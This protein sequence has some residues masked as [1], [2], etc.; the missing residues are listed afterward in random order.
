MSEDKEIVVLEQKTAEE[1]FTAEGKQWIVEK[2]KKHLSIFDYNIATKEGRTAIN[3]MARKIGGLQNR[4]TDLKKQTTAEWK[5]KAKKIDMQGKAIDDALES[6]KQQFREPLT[7]L[8]SL[9]KQRT[10]RINEGRNLL[11]KIYRTEADHEAAKKE[12]EII[13]NFDFADRQEEAD[14]LSK[15]VET[16]L[17]TVFQMLQQEKIKEEEKRAE[18]EKARIEEAARKM[19][20][21][22]IQKMQE[23]Q[24]R[25]KMRQDAEERARIQ[26][27]EDLE[28]RKNV[29]NKI[30]DCLTEIT[31]D[32]E[33]A[34][35]IVIAIAKK[36]IENLSIN[37]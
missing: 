16:H 34:K 1:L 12:S 36:E 7:L 30:V 3:A 15:I 2:V 19:A 20:E 27:E 9:E 31:G 37:Y 29:T 11:Q 26:R 14:N 25:E 21:V 35:K 32:P 24:N 10:D 18:I 28:H 5:E 4:V 33:I 17:N 22:E 6:I 8:E 13:F 23:A